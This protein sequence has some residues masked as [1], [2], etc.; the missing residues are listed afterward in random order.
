[1]NVPSEH[2]KNGLTLDDV[3]TLDEP[4]GGVAQVRPPRQVPNPLDRELP[5][6]E[7]IGKRFRIVGRLGAGGMGEVYRADDLQL[8]MPVALK[9]LPVKYAHDPGRLERL[10]GEVRI[11]RQ[12]SHQNVCRVYDIS[13]ADGLCFLTMEFIDG[14]DLS[15]LLRR[16]G[17]LPPDKAVELARQ[18]VAGVAAAHELDVVH[19]DLKPANVMIDGRGHARV[20]DFGLASTLDEEGRGPRD[21]AGTPVYMAPEQIDGAAP[22]KQSDVYALGLVLYELFTGQPAHVAESLA[23]LRQLHSSSGSLTSP[24]EVVR[25]MDPAAERV[26]LRCLEPDPRDRPMSALS[27]LAALPGGDPLAALLEA[28]ETPSPELVAASGREGGLDLRCSRLLRCRACGGVVDFWRLVDR[29]YSGRYPP[30]AGAGTSG[31]GAA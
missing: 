14:E 6:G 16:I 28:G 3:V 12:V 30:A 5:A 27:V 15:S 26:I 1:V 4:E 19:R 24:S 20:A 29:R 10:R 18:I 22:T 8:G 23:E 17:R 21:L 9:F 13:E 11:A 25:D 7:L 2:N 31:E